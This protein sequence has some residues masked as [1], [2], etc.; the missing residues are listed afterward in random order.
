[1]KERRTWKREEHVEVEEW[2]AQKKG[3][4]SVKER[5]A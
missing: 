3:K 2:R 1:M 5:R 4:E